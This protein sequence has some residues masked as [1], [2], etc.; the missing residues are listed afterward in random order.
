MLYE[1][2]DILD[3]EPVQLAIH[4]PQVSP[5]AIAADGTE[6]S[7]GGEFLGH[8]DTAD[9]AGVPDFVAGLEIMEIFL[10]PIAVRI[11]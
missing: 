5:V 8:L 9:I 11:A 7:E 10:V 2:V 4:Q 6:G 1:H 3:L